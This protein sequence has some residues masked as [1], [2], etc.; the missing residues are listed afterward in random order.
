M[1]RNIND[2][3]QMNT[4][5]LIKLRKKNGEKHNVVEQK[6]CKKMQCH[7]AKMTSTLFYKH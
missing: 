3:M 6:W 5:K 7:H 1:Q 2:Q 4:S